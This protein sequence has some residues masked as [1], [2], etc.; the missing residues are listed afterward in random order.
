MVEK[1]CSRVVILSAGRV[2]G[3]H[4]VADFGSAGADSLEETFVRVTHQADYEPL[5]RRILDTITRE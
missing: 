2:A 4:R 5:A 3:E 1:L